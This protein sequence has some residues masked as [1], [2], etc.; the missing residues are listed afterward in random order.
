[1]AFVRA[2]QRDLRALGYLRDTIDG[3]FGGGT[4]QAVR[5][6]QFD[7]LNHVGG[8]GAPL[9]I[10]NYAKGRISSV[11]GVVEVGLA[12]CID[13]MVNDLTFVKVPSSPNPAAE[14]ARALA[15]IALKDYA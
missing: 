10:Q 8:N 5:S 3:I 7:L 12:A 2:L 1:M 9:A 6:L 14:N 4:E 11:T 15:A 13:D